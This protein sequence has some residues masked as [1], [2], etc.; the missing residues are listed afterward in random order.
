MCVLHDNE[1]L[2]CDVVYANGEYTF[3]FCICV[4]MD[5][6][7][8]YSRSKLASVAIHHI[9]AHGAVVLR[10]IFNQQK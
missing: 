8:L 5:V 1:M 4:L 3:L 7:V 2:E 10:F 6:L 9:I